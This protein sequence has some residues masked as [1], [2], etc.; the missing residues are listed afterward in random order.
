[1]PSPAQALR[2]YSAPR[3]CFVLAIAC[4]CCL[5]LA[6]T[7]HTLH[8]GVKTAFSITKPPLCRVRAANMAYQMPPIT[9]R[10]VFLLFGDSLTQYSF[11]SAGGWG[12]ALA[13]HYQRKVQGGASI[14]RSNLG[15]VAPHRAHRCAAM[16]TCSVG[17]A[18]PC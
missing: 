6:L 2:R 15:A 3:L 10:P 18:Q 4:L 16:T 11:D 7:I 1:M 13:H 8:R 5:T 9:R 17:D 14:G 12:S